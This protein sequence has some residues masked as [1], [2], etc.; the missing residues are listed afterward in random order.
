MSDD[1]R[2][3]SSRQELVELVRANTQGE[4]S[5]TAH[6][7]ARARFIDAV[8]RRHRRASGGVIVGALGLSIGAAALV[9]ALIVRAEPPSPSIACE[10]TSGTDPTAL[11]P[12]VAEAVHTEPSV[13]RPRSFW[14]QA[15]SPR[16]R[17]M[18]ALRPRRVL[19]ASNVPGERP[20]SWAIHGL[21][22]EM[23]VPACLSTPPRGVRRSDAPFLTFLRRK[24]AHHPAP[25]PSLHS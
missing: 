18:P 24:A 22:T 20:T 19:P 21:N 1:E 10:P 6:A 12:S 7:V 8:T 15:S 14:S 5:T 16:V 4:L 3:V 23:P 2:T 11:R 9:G 13:S 17:R 25:H